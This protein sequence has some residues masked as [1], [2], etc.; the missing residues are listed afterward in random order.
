MTELLPQLSNV[1][2]G[3]FAIATMA[4]VGTRYTVHEILGP[5]R[6]FRGVVLA[7]LANFIAVPLLAVVILKLLSPDSAYGNG[8]LLAASAVGAPFVITLTKIPG[9][10]VAFA[11]GLLVL[12]VVVSI[13]HMPLVVPTLAARCRA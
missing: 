12:L 3:L 4:S 10:S 7:L 5:L 6:N 9:G 11:S 1:A 2:V 13:G 8:L